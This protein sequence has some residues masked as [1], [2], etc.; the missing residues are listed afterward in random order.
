M[1][2]SPSLTHKETSIQIKFTRNCKRHAYET[3]QSCWKWRIILSEQKTGFYLTNIF[4]C[5]IILCAGCPIIFPIQLHVAIFFYFFS[6]NRIKPTVQKY[7]F[8]ISHFSEQFAVTQ[9][10]FVKATFFNDVTQIDFCSTLCYAPMRRILVTIRVTSFVNSSCKW[11]WV[12][13]QMLKA[14]PLIPQTYISWS[15]MIGPKKRR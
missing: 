11:N 10:R 15:S 13:R 7:S 9:L 2:S 12:M 14:P 5:K 3:T 6:D 8:E 1:L 4:F